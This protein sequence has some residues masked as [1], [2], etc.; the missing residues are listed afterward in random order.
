MEWQ[1][2]I[3]IAHAS[4]NTKP[5]R[6]EG[7]ISILLDRLMALAATERDAALMRLQLGLD[8]IDQ[9]CVQTIHGFCNKVLATETL[10]C[11]I[12]AGFIVETNPTEMKSDAIKDTWRTDL[13]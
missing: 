10:L 8:D 4:A 2:A 5:K 9:L 1:L 13:A 12:S 3:L 11:G 6:E 7:G